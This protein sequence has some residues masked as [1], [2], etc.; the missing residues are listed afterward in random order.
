MNSFTQ[1]IT[2]PE[3][4]TLEWHSSNTPNPSTRINNTTSVSDGT[5]YAVFYDS[6]NG[7]YSPVTPVIISSIY[8]D[9]YCFIPAATNGPIL[10]TNVGISTI[11]QPN[12]WPQNRT[13]AQLVL[14][15]ESKGFV[16]NRLTTLQINA[17]ETPVEGMIAYDIDVNC[18]KIYSKNVD[19][20]FTWKCFNVQSCP[21]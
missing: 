6:I 20:T 7:C 4:A 5:Y 15:S 12:G 14:E 10:N 2:I 13:G 3:G 17:I 11:G 9:P 18:L 8:C 16:L 21:N 19:N 1:G